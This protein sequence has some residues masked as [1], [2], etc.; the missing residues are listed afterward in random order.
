MFSPYLKISPLLQ[1]IFKGLYLPSKGI[2]DYFQRTVQGTV[3]SK[4]RQLFRCDRHK[5]NTLHF[6]N[7]NNYYIISNIVHH[8]CYE[9]DLKKKIC[10]NFFILTLY[11]LCQ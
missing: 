9:T 11:N 10:I 3:P 1:T 5:Q 8:M 2:K 6:I 4:K 7:N